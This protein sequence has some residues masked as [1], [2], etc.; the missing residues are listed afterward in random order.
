MLNTSSL[1]Q[2]AL[3]NQLGKYQAGSVGP[4]GVSGAGTSAMIDTGGDLGME[5]EFEAFTASTG[6]HKVCVGGTCA[7]VVTK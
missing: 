3:T 1:Y 4:M 7:P 5:Y 2:Q 6:G